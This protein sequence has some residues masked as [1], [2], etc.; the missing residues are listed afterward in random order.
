VKHGNLSQV[1][2]VKYCPD[3]QGNF[4]S[5]LMVAGIANPYP[6][7]M[8][9]KER[10]RRLEKLIFPD[11]YQFS[12]KDIDM[13]IQKFN[14]IFGGNKIIVTTEKDMGRLN[15][16]GFIEKIK[17]LPI[18]YMPIEIKLH[19]SDKEDFNN[20]ILEYVKKN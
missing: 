11:H 12:E 6:L 20:Q 13:I 3:D 2:G 4:S 17:S 7:E 10:C 15:Q 14:D 1:P 19:K 18:C 5:I 8:K 16:P 9:L